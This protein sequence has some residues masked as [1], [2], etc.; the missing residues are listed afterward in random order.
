MHILMVL[1]MQQNSVSFLFKE[2]YVIML[3]YYCRSPAAGP[4]NVFGTL[5]YP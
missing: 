1:E 4:V 3:H 2:T 5:S